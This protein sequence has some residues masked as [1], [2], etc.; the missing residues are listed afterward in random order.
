M[1]LSW[2]KR[3]KFLYTTVASVIGAIALVSAYYTFFTHTP[4]CFDRTQNG[5]ERGV[6]CGGSC[7]LLCQDQSKPARVQ[8]SRIFKTSDGVYTVAAYVQ[9]D[10]VGAGARK[11]GYSFQIF[12]ANNSLIIERDGVVDFPPVQ[13]IPIVEQ[14]IRIQNREPARVLFGLAAEPVWYKVSVP[15]L[16]VKNLN[17]AEDASK[18]QAVLSND[19]TKDTKVSVAA[20]LFDAQGVARAASRSQLTVPKKSSSPV[21]FTFPGGVPDIVRAEVTVLPAF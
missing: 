12:D 10:N 19:S 14:N 20:V 5:D 11:V 15:K 17:L 13:T 9:N 2:G 18:L 4:S 7:S 6:D 16:V 1:A 8:W 3:R 21:V